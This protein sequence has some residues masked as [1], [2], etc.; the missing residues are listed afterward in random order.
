MNHN[1]SLKNS[2]CEMEQTLVTSW[3]DSKKNFVSSSQYGHLS[4]HPISAKSHSYLENLVSMTT[5]I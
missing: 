3:D 4:P 1:A 2:A 5:R